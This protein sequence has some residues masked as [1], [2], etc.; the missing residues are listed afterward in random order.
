MLNLSLKL[1]YGLLTLIELADYVDAKPLQLKDISSRH[2][3]PPKYLEQVISVLRQ[4]GFVQ[5][6][7]GVNGGYT[8]AKTPE[9]ISVLEVVKVLQGVSS[10]DPKI[11]GSVL[12]GYW[13]GVLLG[14]DRLVDYTLAEFIATCCSA[15]RLSYSI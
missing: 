11:K 3:I 9:E 12:E 6:L 2:Q 7:R 8:L 15:N 4:S 13:Q 10:I 1:H 14:A 5:S